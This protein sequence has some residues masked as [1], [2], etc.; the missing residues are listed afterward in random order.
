MWNKIVETLDKL[1]YIPLAWVIALP[2]AFLVL[3]VTISYVIPPTIVYDCTSTPHKEAL[4][5][6]SDQCL[7]LARTVGLKRCTT[8]VRENYCKPMLENK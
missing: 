2:I 6:S 5:D 8:V 7:A 4:K 3:F 1:S